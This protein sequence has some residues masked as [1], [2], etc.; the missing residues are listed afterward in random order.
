MGEQRPEVVGIQEGLA[1]QWSWLDVRDA[2]VRAASTIRA[3]PRE[4]K[5]RV[6]SGWP[7]Y[8]RGWDAYDNE[9]AASVKPASPPPHLIDEADA[10]IQWLYWVPCE[11][12]RR[13]VAAR[14]F[15][16]TWRKIQNMDGRSESTLRKR[17]RESLIGIAARLNT[18]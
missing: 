4:S 16:V 1:H 11:P 18:K 15:G 9:M 8:V 14:M 3:M 7:D 2:M 17:Y 13:V 5:R 12:D 10:A 6:R